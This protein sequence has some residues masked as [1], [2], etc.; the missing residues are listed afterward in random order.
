[1]SL[2]PK[3]IYG[4]WNEG[5]VLDDHIIESIYLGIDAYGHAMYDNTRSKL[6]DLLYNF[7]YKNKHD[8]LNNI[9]TLIKPFLKQWKALQNINIVMPVPPSNKN[10]DYQPVTE[11]AN[12]IATVINKPFT[13]KILT[14][15][16]A[17]ES[18]NSENKPKIKN[19]IKALQKAKS[20]HSILLVDDLYDTGITL[21]EC[22]SVLQKDPLLLEI[23]VLAMTK[24][25]G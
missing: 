23:Y 25:K 4:K 6:G 20:K 22:V 17:I 12:S 13:D 10:R 18:K 8:N 5:Y 9:I 21:N 3:K 7:K 15:Q 16:S 19:S 1:M 2:N 11:L 14:K 24:T